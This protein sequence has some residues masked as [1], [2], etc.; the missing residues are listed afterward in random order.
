M[1]DLQISE[2]NLFDFFILQQI[3]GT[4]GA[5]KTGT[6]NEHPHSKTSPK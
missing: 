4:G 3:V 5:L 6:E 1:A 2:S